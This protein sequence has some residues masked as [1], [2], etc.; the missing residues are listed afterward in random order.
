MAEEKKHTLQETQ[1]KP[2]TQAEPQSAEGIQPLAAPSAAFVRTLSKILPY[3]GTSTQN[4]ILK[5]ESVALATGAQAITIPL[6]GA[7]VDANGHAPGNFLGSTVVAG[8]VRVKCFGA[9]GT[10]THIKVVAS[11]GTNN[12]VLE[13]TELDVA[14]SATNA[15]DKLVAFLSDLNCKQ[16]TI[17]VTG[18]G[19]TSHASV[20]VAGSSGDF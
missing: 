10:V 9:S 13:D 1:P 19:T 16:F 3:F 15:V 4:P 14:L 7:G 20:E 5:R 11:D 17:T 8:Y 2:H 12:E 6:A 18:G